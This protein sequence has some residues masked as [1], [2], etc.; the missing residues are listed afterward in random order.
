LEFSARAKAIAPIHMQRW[1]E[2]LQGCHSDQIDVLLNTENFFSLAPQE[3]AWWDQL[4]QSAPFAP[5]LA[6]HG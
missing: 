4:I 1:I 2:I 3:Q 6:K 5:V